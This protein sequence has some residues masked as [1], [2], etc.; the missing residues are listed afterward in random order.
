[1]TESDLKTQGMALAAK[2]NS[3]WLREA[4]AVAIRI[5]IDTGNCS[6]DDVRRHL[7]GL[8]AKKF[9]GSVF[10]NG[11]WEYIKHVPATHAGSHGRFVILWRY[12]ESAGTTKLPA[13]KRLSPGASAGA[14][15]TPAPQDLFPKVKQSFKNQWD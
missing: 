6:I 10:K 12:S 1:M 8:Q 13:V 11:P 4:R 14:P 3:A 2:T 5:G 15:N 9:L 7:P